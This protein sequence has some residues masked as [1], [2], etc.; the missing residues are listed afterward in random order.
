MKAYKYCILF[1]LFSANSQALDIARAYRLIPHQQTPFYLKQS[2]LPDPEARYISKLLGLSELAMA[3]RVEAMIDGPDKSRYDADITTILGKLSKLETPAKLRPVY[4]H[5]VTAIEE[6]RSYFALEISGDA[7][8]E[9]KQEQLVNSSSQHLIAAHALLRQL[10]PQETK[11]N[12]QAFFD[13]LCA[14]DFI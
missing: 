9:V 14:L 5:I 13:Y 3:E 8:A 4:Q 12:K 10:Y 1:L 11:H 6:H 2:N 7:N